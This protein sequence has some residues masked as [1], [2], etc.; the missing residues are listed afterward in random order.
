MSKVTE[1]DVIRLLEE[2]VEKLQNNIKKT[3]AALA[4]LTGSD[5]SDK[6]KLK[7]K[8][9]KIIKEAKEKI[10]KNLRKKEKTQDKASSGTADK[11]SL[12]T[13]SVLAEI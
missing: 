9:R 7:K 6:T 8:D 1:K 2:R 12:E 10:K 3:E 5:E 4:V 11:S 13:F